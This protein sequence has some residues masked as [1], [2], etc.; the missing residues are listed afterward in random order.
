MGLIPKNAYAPLDFG[1][2][3][4]RLSTLQT[5]NLSKIT[6]GVKGSG[7]G[8]GFKFD[9]SMLRYAPVLGSALSVAGDLLG[10][11]KPDYTNSNMIAKANR[12]ISFAPIG[13]YMDYNPLDRDYYLNKMNQQASATRDAIIN[14][15]GGNRATATAGLLASDFNA[16]GKV[17]DLARMAEEYNAA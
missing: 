13:D 9:T 16:Q 3:E 12:P 5:N 15:A 7:I 10:N 14:N 6:N 11:N 8:N 4:N 2:E 1:L 17:G